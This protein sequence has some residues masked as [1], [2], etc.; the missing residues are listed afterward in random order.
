MVNLDYTVLIQMG[1]FILLIFL[2]NILLYKPILSIIDKRRKTLEDSDLEIKNLRETVDRRM[3]EY[4]EKL[5]LAKQEALEQKAEIVKEGADRAK[6]IIDTVRNE[7]PA[8]MEQFQAKMGKEVGEAK[9]ILRSQSQKISLEI[10]EKVLGR[11]I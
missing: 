8:I 3:A 2:L 1:N 11:S 4:E 9:D 7:L 10:A 6:G 5:R